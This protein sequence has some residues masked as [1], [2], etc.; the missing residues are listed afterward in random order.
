M[1]LIALATMSAAQNSEEMSMVKVEEIYEKI[2]NSQPVEYDHVII[3]GDLNLTKLYLPRDQNGNKIVAS[4]IQIKNSVFETNLDFKDA[5][6][7][8]SIDFKGSTFI[9]N[10]LFSGAQVDGSATFEDV[11][12]K[13]EASFYKSKFKNRANFNKAE[14]GGDATF[15]EVEFDDAGFYESN[16]RGD[17]TFDGSKFNGNAYFDGTR[18]NSYVYFGNALFSQD[19]SFYQTKFDW[20][21]NFSSA[22]FGGMS[23]F[24][25]AYFA[26]NANF[27]NAEFDRYVSFDNV[28]FEKDADFKGTQFNRDSYFTGTK[29][30]GNLNLD[31]SHFSALQ[32][33]WAAIKDHL[34]YNEAT[35]V[36]LIKD[37]EGLGYF[38]DA[39]NSYYQYRKEN[40]A[41][42]TSLGIKLM[43]ILAWLTC[44]YGVRP[45]Y[46]V[47]FSILVCLIFAIFYW[48]GD[49]VSKCKCALS[50]LEEVQN[51]PL[52]NIIYF[53]VMAFVTPHVSVEWLPSGNWK[54]VVLLEH[55]MGWMIMALFLVT[56][57]KVMIR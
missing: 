47:G 1:I 50:S 36:A 9:E 27:E 39:D 44:G 25:G 55:I 43:D 18:F 34:L 41:R 29:F 2:D 21:A 40:Q 15:Y 4:S 49:V 52:V 6:F 31:N 33:E 46:T 5:V 17:A 26:K 22:K 54:F 11:Q 24:D 45:L 56:L 28:R 20:N 23:Y 37:Y 35:Y 10:A 51:S 53:S 42:E 14:F 38:N 12:F 19:A 48:A 32:I 30:G 57:G 8:E 3:I 7:L 16:F 13:K